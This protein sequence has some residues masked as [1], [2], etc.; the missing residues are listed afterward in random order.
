[1]FLKIQIRVVACFSRFEKSCCLFHKIRSSTVLPP[2]VLPSE[3]ASVCSRTGLLVPAAAI[4]Q[5]KFL[6][7]PP[8]PAPCLDNPLHLHPVVLQAWPTKGL[9]QRDGCSTWTLTTC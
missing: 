6:S 9:A 1:M 5:R 2:R 3:S 8:N 7:S 4:P